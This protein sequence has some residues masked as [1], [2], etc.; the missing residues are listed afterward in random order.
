M[1]DETLYIAGTFRLVDKAPR[2][3][4]LIQVKSGDLDG[5]WHGVQEMQPVY[6]N[7]V[8]NFVHPSRTKRELISS[9]IRMFPPK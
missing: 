3:A 1:D 2:V 6:S 8:S 7:P 9:C 4:H 5:P